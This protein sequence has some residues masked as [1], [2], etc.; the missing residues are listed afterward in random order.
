VNLTEKGKNEDELNRLLWIQGIRPLNEDEAKRLT[1]LQKLFK[2]RAHLPTGISP[3]EGYGIE[4]NDFSKLLKLQTQGALNS[5]LLDYLDALNDALEAA[6]YDL[7][8]NE[9]NEIQP[10]MSVT[11]EQKASL[12]ERA[13]DFLETKYGKKVE[14]EEEKP[15]KISKEGKV[16]ASLRQDYA[17]LKYL[18][19]VGMIDKSFADETLEY[20]DEN[21]MVP[22]SALIQIYEDIIP[23]RLTIDGKTMDSSYFDNIPRSK[24]K[25]SIQRVKAIYDRYKSRVS[26]TL[27][28]HQF[29]VT[30]VALRIAGL[31]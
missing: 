23:S 22:I 28:T 26:S 8:P 30:R 18:D 10:A 25:P 24:S 1:D 12:L 3:G 11:P 29:K 17:D 5:I 27:A 16:N 15:E 20:G 6:P 2:G 14:V 31:A 13:V 4:L 7:T 9:I 19:Y 21:S